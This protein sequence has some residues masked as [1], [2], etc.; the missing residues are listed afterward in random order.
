MGDIIVDEDVT[1]LKHSDK[2]NRYIEYFSKLVFEGMILLLLNL[3]FGYYIL[4]GYLLS[5]ILFIP[6]PIPK[7]P[8]RYRI[9]SN[10]IIL[11]KDKLFKMKKTYILDIQKNYLSIYYRYRE[12]LRLYSEDPYKLSKILYEIRDK[13]RE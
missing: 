12:I 2:K 1:N 9:I 10:C 3:F 11:N 6:L 13:N 7:I 5:L 4:L 8:H